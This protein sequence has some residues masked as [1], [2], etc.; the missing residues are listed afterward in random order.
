[1][2]VLSYQDI[3]KELGKGIYFHPLKPG[4]VKD[5][6]LCLT[7]GE[8]A[9]SLTDEKRLTIGTEQNPQGEE[10]KYFD[11]PKN[12]TALVWTSEAIWLSNKFRGPLYSVVKQVS[13][14][15]GHIGT[16]VNP[17]WASVLC[18]ALHNVSNKPIRIYVGDVDNPI[19]HLAIEK[20]SSKCLNPSKNHK[21]DHTPGRLD[22]IRGLSNTQEINDY[23]NAPENGWMMHKK[24]RL[25]QLMIESDEYKKL[26]KGVK[27]T[28]LD[29]LG[30]TE[31]S[32]W[33][34][35]NMIVNILLLGLGT[36]FAALTYLNSHQSS[37]PSPT[38]T[39]LTPKSTKK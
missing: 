17:E 26:K 37:N 20:L 9:Y 36:L 7:A 24:D 22:V 14:G 5:C 34:R 32:R 21:Q 1:M 33:N 29:F 10:R 18:I 8:C 11:I 13:N 30:S 3:I 4:S 27:E 6:D 31:D 12:D 35:V 28:L 15:L 16:R 39:I 2:S 25:K 23:F 19:A 38:N